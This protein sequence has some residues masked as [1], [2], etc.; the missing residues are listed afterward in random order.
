MLQTPT[1]KLDRSAQVIEL[2]A[3]LPEQMRET[4]TTAKPAPLVVRPAEL[5]R[6]FLAAPILAAK[7]K[8]FDDDVVATLE[9]HHSPRVMA[10]LHD[11]LK[12]IG[13]RCVGEKKDCEE[14]ASRVV[15]ALSLGGERIDG[16]APVRGADVGGERMA[17]EFHDALAKPIGIFAE[18]DDL[19]EI[20]RRDRFLQQPMEDS[21]ADA[22]RSSMVRDAEVMAEYRHALAFQSRITNPPARPSLL[23]DAVKGPYGTGRR[24]FLPASDAFENGIIRQYQSLLAGGAD[25]TDVLIAALRDRRL[26]LA[27]KAE[28]GWYAWQWWAMEP[29]LRESARPEAARVLRTPGYQRLVEDEF[30]AVFTQNRETHVKN[31]A[32]AAVCGVPERLVTIGPALTVEPHAERCRRLS[33]AYR[34]LRTAMMELLGEAALA[35]PLRGATTDR[36][37]PAPCS[38]AEGLFAME[39]LFFGG[40]LVA[41]DETGHPPALE[42]RTARE[43]E[44]ARHAL[45]WFRANAA[46]DRHLAADVRV[47]VPLFFN[48]QTRMYRVRGLF[49]Y[50]TTWGSAR[51][52]EKP[53]IC[54]PTDGLRI[55]WSDQSLP[56]VRMETAEFEV[57]VPPTREEFRA[58]CDATDSVAEAVA[59]LSGE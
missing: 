45:R 38:L 44:R 29:L 52:I 20:F 49:A 13:K 12:A 50:S 41:C 42:D 17:R 8:A 2:D 7:A 53:R 11:C 55:V 57:A 30:R 21:V 4:L 43:A 32:M 36:N 24:A 34:F 54:S 58:A 14:A 37:A 59:R 51:F 33:L 35:A 10:L 23:S 15:A 1:L 48:E 39:D 16:R 9:R 46:S 27:P 47:A 56:L 26:D 22:L 40:Y 25:T 5:V 28:S 3:P 31:L 19:G 18:A 6:G